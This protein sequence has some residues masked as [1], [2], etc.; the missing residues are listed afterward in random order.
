MTALTVRRLANLATPEH[1]GREPGSRTQWLCDPNAAD[2]PSSSL[3]TFEHQNLA[4]PSGF[5]PESQPAEGWAL[6]RWTMDRNQIGV[7]GGNRILV[8]GSTDR[9][10]STRPR[11][12]SVPATPGELGGRGGNRTPICW[13]Q[14]SGPTVERLPQTWLRAGELNAT[15]MAYE[16]SMTPVH[17][18]A[19]KTD[20]DSGARGGIRNPNLRFTRAALVRLSYSGAYTHSSWSGCR[21]S[22]SVNR[23]GGPM[24]S[25]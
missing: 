23:T 4:G 15:R 21:E 20:R 10:L 11:P 22:N 5:E 8:D 3:P 19:S 7:A 9:R 2:L 14:A 1:F 12:H 18:P 17:L 16:A 13:L 25:Q 24:P 6:S